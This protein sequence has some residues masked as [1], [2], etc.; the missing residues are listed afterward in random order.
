MFRWFINIFC[1]KK[2]CEEGAICAY[3]YD[4]TLYRTIQE[5]EWAKREKIKAQLVS[6]LQGIFCRHS[7]TYSYS[8]PDLLTPA[9][10]ARTVVTYWPEVASLASELQESG[11]S[12]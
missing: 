9:E 11:E 1:K 2:D 8:S 7:N 6:H 5:V 12:T 4:G 10:A 3:E